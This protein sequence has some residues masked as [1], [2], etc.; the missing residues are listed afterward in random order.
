MQLESTNSGATHGNILKTL[1]QSIW[2]KF[3]LACVHVCCFS[4][5]QSTRQPSRREILEED[6]Q[7][8][9]LLI[10]GSQSYSYASNTFPTGSSDNLNNEIDGKTLK[11]LNQ[12]KTIHPQVQRKS[13]CEQLYQTQ[14]LNFY[15]IFRSLPE[16]DNVS[17][18]DED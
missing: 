2:G 8:K 12:P 4:C 3:N 6:E 11:G 5:L 17:D 16:N 13:V 14:R 15:E 7:L 1:W 10:R 18:S 9:T